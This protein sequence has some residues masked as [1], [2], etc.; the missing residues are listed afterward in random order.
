[1]KSKIQQLADDLVGT[2]DDFDIEDYTQDELIE[3]DNQIFRCECC[4]WWC[5]NSENTGDEICE[6]CNDD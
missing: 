6:D 2:A 5:E 4:G 1:M 3:L